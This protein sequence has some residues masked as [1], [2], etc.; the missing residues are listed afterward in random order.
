MDLLISPDTPLENPSIFPPPLPVKSC[1]LVHQELPPQ[2]LPQPEDR[3]SESPPPLTRSATARVSFRE[4]IS[5]SYS[6]EEDEDEDEN[7][8]QLQ[9]NEEN[10]PDEDEVEGGFG[11]RLCLQKGIPPQMDILGE[12]WIFNE[13]D[14]ISL[15]RLVLRLS[16]LL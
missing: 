11:S 16:C 1:D 6:V 10:Q 3:S 15:Q 12:S 13:N 9:E 8:E 5:S 2:N 4:P 14:C 7:E